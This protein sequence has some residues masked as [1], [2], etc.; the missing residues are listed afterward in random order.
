MSTTTIRIPDD[1]KARVQNVAKARG[2]SA[3]ALIIEAI[4]EKADNGERRMDFMDSANAR[5]TEIARSGETVTWTAMR[6]YLKARISA[7][8]VERPKARK[9]VVSSDND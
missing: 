7:Q 1:L 3:H 4:A 2:L 6:T 5:M 9:L 8:G